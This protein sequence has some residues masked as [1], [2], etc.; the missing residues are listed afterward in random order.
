MRYYRLPG[1]ERSATDSLVVVADNGTAYDL[2]SASPDLGSFRAL[3]R[4]ANANDESIDTIARKR[5]D[6]SDRI[7]RDVLEENAIQPV[8]ADEVWAAGVTYRISE[9]ARESESGKPEVYIDVY[10]SD[11]PELFLKATPS[12][13]VGPLEEIGVRGDSSW[14]VPEPELGVVLHRGDVVGYTIGNDVS[15]RDIEGKNPLYLPQAKVYDRCCSIGPC[16]STPETI[17]DPHDLTMSLV[18]ERDGEMVYEGS[19]ST[20]EMTT[21]CEELVSYLRRHNNLPETLILL[22]GTALVPPETF[23]LLEGDEVTIDID[24][25]GRLVNKTVTV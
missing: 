19:T 20:G 15:S 2:T 5:L 12:R 8:I 14:N 3:A 1:G 18:I 22:T 9:E 4:A 25:I 24:Q 21:S 17:T 11:R 10:E 13:T 16:V 6:D 7:D 23:T